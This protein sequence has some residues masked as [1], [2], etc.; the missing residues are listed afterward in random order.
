[1]LI[2]LPIILATARIEAGRRVGGDLR[3]QVHASRNHGLHD[4]WGWNQT[5]LHRGAQSKNHSYRHHHN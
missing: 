1:M 2:G 5:V 4:A 3:R